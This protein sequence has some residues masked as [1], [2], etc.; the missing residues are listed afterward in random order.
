MLHLGKDTKLNI[1]PIYV[2]LHHDYVF[3]GPCR[4]GKGFELTKEFDD[5]A[6]Q[7]LI[8][9]ADEELAE[10]LASPHFNVMEPLWMD[11]N[12]EFLVTPAMLEEMLADRD[13]VDVYLV[14]PMGRLSDLMID[15][16]QK[17]GKPMVLIPGPQCMQ[18]IM[19]AST[20]ARMAS[21]G[22]E[23]VSWRSSSK[24]RAGTSTC[25]SIRSSRGPESRAR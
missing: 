8:K 18:T 5:M 13:Q 25:R 9:G 1:K 10:Q 6:N 14:G 17:A 7:E 16:G 21:E 19:A 22:S 11:R 12:E 4:M 15:F 23:G 24:F 2:T 3:E 20:R